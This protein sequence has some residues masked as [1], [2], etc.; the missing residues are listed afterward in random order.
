MSQKS[1]N[2]VAEASATVIASRD[3]VWEALVT[4]SEI[5]RY[6][7]GAEVTSDWRPGSPIT[8]KGEWEGK[9]YQDHGVIK[10]AERARVLEY[11]HFSPLSGQPDLPENHHTVTIELSIA[12]PG[13]TRVTL[14]QDNNATEEACARS[15]KNWEAMLAELKKLV[16]GAG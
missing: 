11:T 8:W 13:A 6:M 15:A 2:L 5:K 10:R 12:G 16:E 9:P 4:P 14:S 1:Q 7:F 3:R